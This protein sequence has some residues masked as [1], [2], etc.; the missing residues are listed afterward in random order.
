MK[1]KWVCS[2][3]LRSLTYTCA[4]RMLCINEHATFKPPPNMFTQ[5]W[6]RQRKSLRISQY[7]Q[8]FKSR[9]GGASVMMCFMSVSKDGFG[10]VGKEGGGGSRSSGVN[11][12]MAELYG[13][14]WLDSGDAGKRTQAVDEDARFRQWRGRWCSINFQ[15]NADRRHVEVA[16]PM[17]WW[18]DS[19]HDWLKAQWIVT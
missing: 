14:I 6:L 9:A 13:S 7:T 17:S 10:S 19:Q 1:G 16:D 11:R 12:S 5:C 8:L 4:S 15:G 3:R 18:S 2:W